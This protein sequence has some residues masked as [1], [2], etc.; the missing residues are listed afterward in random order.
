MIFWN[1]IWEIDQKMGLSEIQI[2]SKLLKCN[3]MTV[4]D[5]QSPLN[6]LWK[7]STYF[8]FT[9]KILRKFQIHKSSSC[10]V[11]YFLFMLRKDQEYYS[12]YLCNIRTDCN[13]IIFNPIWSSTESYLVLIVWRSIDAI[14]LLISQDR[15]IQ[16]YIMI[17]L[18][19]LHSI[20]F[21]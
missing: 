21:L 16:F 20:V 13:L 19:L 6:Q 12:I 18:S 15:K 10:H 11:F 3:N 7:P 14:L 1:I 9:P 17:W 8:T 5:W 2:Y 4:L